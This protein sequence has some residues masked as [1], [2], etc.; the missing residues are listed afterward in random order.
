MEE[1]KLSKLPKLLHL[2]K[3]NSRPSNV[4][5]NLKTLEISECCNLE[6]FVPSWVSFQNLTTMEVSKCDG[7]ITLLT[8]STAKSLVNLK[9]MQVIDCKM[10]EEIIHV[11]DEVKKGCI[12]FSQLEYLRLTCLPSFTSFCLENYRLKF[13][14]LEQ[15]IVK[16]CPKMEIF[17]RGDLITPKLK[18][19]QLTE[20]QD[21]EERWEGSLNST[22]QK[23]F[24]EMVCIFISLVFVHFCFLLILIHDLFYTP[25]YLSIQHMYM[26]TYMQNVQSI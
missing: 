18:R 7:L 25:E 13:P 1:L 16:E 15:V 11:R 4:F 10:I 24:E 8:F 19:L 2:Y 12:I 20:L 26:H 14:S 9:R 6:K 17:S 5:H 23:L 3:E 21:I 22:I